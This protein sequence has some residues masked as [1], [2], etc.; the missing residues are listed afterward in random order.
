[1]ADQATGTSVLADIY[2]KMG[3]EPYAPIDLD[4]L[5]KRLAIHSEHGKI[6]FNNPAPLARIRR[7]ITTPRRIQYASR[8]T[9]EADRFPL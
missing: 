9:S 2:K 3:E 6:V 1:M 8:N 4:L 5:W 7:A